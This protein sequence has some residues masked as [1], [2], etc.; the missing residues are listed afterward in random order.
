MGS[1]R[2]KKKRKIRESANDVQ[3]HKT[4]PWASN[5]RKLSGTNISISDMKL[6][7]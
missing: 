7:K 6:V 4:R 5:N 2:E 3:K 1:Q